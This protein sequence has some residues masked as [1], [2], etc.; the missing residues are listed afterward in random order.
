MCWARLFPFSPFVPLDSSVFPFI[1]IYRILMHVE[2]LRSTNEGKGD[3]CL[4]R[5]AQFT[6]Y[7]YL[8][9]YPFS[10]RWYTSFIM[11]KSIPHFLYPFPGCWMARLV[12]YFP[13][14]FTIVN[15]AIVNSGVQL[16]LWYV[17]FSKYEWCSWRCILVHISPVTSLMTE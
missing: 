7:N 8:L 5:L 10:C 17:D 14:A 15:S 13:I 9:L 2:N 1:Y 4:F 11:P 12:P 3:I 16:F 6:Y